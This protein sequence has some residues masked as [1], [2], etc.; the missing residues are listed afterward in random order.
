MSKGNLF[1]GFG[2]GSV[3]DVVFSHVDG[4]QV[5][6]A[7]NRSPRN[8]KTALQLLQR[9][10]LKT[11]SSAYSL[12]QDICNHSFQGFA[13]GTP[14]QAQF[15]KIN[16]GKFREQLAIEINSGDESVILESTETNFAAKTTSLV[17]INPYTV[18]DGSLTKL[19]IKFY[20]SAASPAF[21]IALPLPSAAPTYQE[22]LTAYGL[23]RGDQLTFLSLSV[24]DTQEVGQ[25]NG[26]DYARVILDP[27]N[28]IMTSPF[29]SGTAINSPNE[30]NRGGFSFFIV[31]D[32]TQ[33]FLT[34]VCNKHAAASGLANSAAAGTAIV[35]RLAGGVW[36]RSPQALVLRSW[37]ITQPGH[38]Q[39]DHDIDYLSDAILSY[40]SS[41]SSTLYLNQA[42]I[43][44]PEVAPALL[45]SVTLN[46]NPVSR[47]SNANGNSTNTVAGTMV[48]GVAG[49]SYKLA[50]YTWSG[51]APGTKIIDAAFSGDSA[52]TGPTNYSNGQYVI[53][54]T[55]GTNILDQYSKFVVDG[56]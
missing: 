13:E 29:L 20:G 35:S 5:A 53:C 18:S 1:L 33:Y 54:L 40:M 2:R 42:G 39:S 49:T 26:F 37:I 24:D 23:Q 45:A 36:Q 11:T 56:D 51:S 27:D 31:Q 43:T 12:L 32:S 19:P 22:V 3:G 41:D 10:C 4:E 15:N 21:G 25:F 17:E 8:P 7:R 55:D 28:A 44:G 34:W 50:V 16:I 48:N 38:L 6:R 46:N 14:S 30:R 9:V 47:G 52:T